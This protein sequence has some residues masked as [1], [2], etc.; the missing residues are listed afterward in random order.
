MVGGSDVGGDVN[1]VV[2]FAFAHSIGGGGH[3][4][5]MA[6]L[7]ESVEQSHWWCCAGCLLFCRLLRAAAAESAATRTAPTVECIAVGEYPVADWT[8][9]VTPER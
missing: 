8:E 4:G 2:V 1:R 3:G 7:G 9:S 5:P 6:G